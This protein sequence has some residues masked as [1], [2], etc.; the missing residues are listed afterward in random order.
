[1]MSTSW[2]EEDDQILAQIYE[3]RKRET[4]REIPE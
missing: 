1:M 3:E 4:R 2:T